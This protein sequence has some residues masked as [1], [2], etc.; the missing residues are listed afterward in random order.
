MGE[1]KLVVIDATGPDNIGLLNY[2]TLT[3]WGEKI[4]PAS[5]PKATPDVTTVKP[6]PDSIS[7]STGSPI[8]QSSHLNASYG[9]STETSAL[10]LFMIFAMLIG[11]IAYLIYTRGGARL[12]TNR[13]RKV[14]LEKEIDQEDLKLQDFDE[15]NFDAL[16]YTDNPSDLE[17]P[18][19][20]RESQVLFQRPTN[21]SS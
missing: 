7:N 4:V 11:G 16:A 14:I 19:E 2:W 17:D 15:A 12:L 8:D 6:S 10:F 3:L 5:T 18:I 9:S 21:D 1:W 20:V 13:R